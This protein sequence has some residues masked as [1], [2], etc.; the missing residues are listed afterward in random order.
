MRVIPEPIASILPPLVDDLR[1]TLGDDLVAV[2]LYGSAVTGG[3][4]PGASDLDL[5]IVTERDAADLD[6]EVL[7]GIHQRLVEREP[8]WGDR[9]DLA[10][11]GRRTLATF[12]DGGSLASISHD[13]PLQ[14][15]DE[16]DDWLQTWYLVREADTPIVGP[17]A[18]EL[19]APIGRAEFVRAVARHVDRLVERAATDLRPGPQSYTIVTLCRVLIA[20]ETGELVSKKDAVAEIARRRP[21]WASVLQA[22]EEVHETRGREAMPAA[23]R[24]AAP[25]IIAELAAEIRARRAKQ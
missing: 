7:E 19:I 25:A 15:Y 16:A 14:R 20:L 21:D 24:E 23:A 18:P 8:D 11:V 9:L 17:P 22:S 12:R 5:V 1:A 4:E 6:L 2:Y 10:Y 13:E 3:F